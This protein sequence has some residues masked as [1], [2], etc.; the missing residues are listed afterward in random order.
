[1]EVFKRAAN[2]WTVSDKEGKEILL[3]Y[4]FQ[5]EL[6]FYDGNEVIDISEVVE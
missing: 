5:G 1:M 2:I 4:L 6:E 3:I